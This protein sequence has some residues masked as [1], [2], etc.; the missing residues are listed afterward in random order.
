MQCEAV[1]DQ[2]SKNL[3]FYKEQRKNHR[4]VSPKLVQSNKPTAH[5]INSNTQTGMQVELK[6]KARKRGGLYGIKSSDDTGDSLETTYAQECS[7]KI[8]G[9]MKL[10]LL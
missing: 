7:R 10:K 6:E 1:N 3:T 5:K 8:F 4:V 2:R 9:C